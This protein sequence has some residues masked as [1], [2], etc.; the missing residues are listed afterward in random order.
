MKRIITIFA[1][2]LAIAG[3]GTQVNAQARQWTLRECIDYAVEHNIEIRQTALNVENAEIDLNTTQNSRLPNLNAG[4]GQNFSFGRTSVDVGGETPEYRNTQT[5]NTSAS[6]SAGMPLFQGFRISNQ[7]KADKLDLQAATENLERA[8]Q[9]LEL[10]VAALYLDVLFKK[11]I[12]AVY[13]EQTSLTRRQVDN[14]RRMVDEGKVARAQLLDIEAQLARNE[15]NEVTASNDLALS[16]L[17]LEQA[18]DLVPSPDFDV[19][20]VDADSLTPAVAAAMRSPETI[21]QTALGI[22]PSVREAQLRLRSAE[23]GVKI[24]RSAFFPSLSLSANAGVGYMY[25]FGQ[26]FPQASLAD[27]I[28]N[29]HSESVGLNLSI[30]IFNRNATRNGVRAARLGVMNQTLALDGVRLA[31][32]KEIQQAWQSAVAAEVRF[33]ATTKA[34]AASEEAFRA[35]ELRYNNGKATVYE[36][37]DANTTLIASRSEQTR[38][39]FDYLFSTKILEFYAGEQIDI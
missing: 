11:E 34:L 33:D 36:Y 30:P 38:A 2:L 18:L 13:R 23:Y 21:Y 6:I 17:N 15:V 31:L 9:N 37:S 1:G 20:E 35:M 39:R 24:A 8:K 7:L 26:D 3:T 4:L 16:L 14:T 19:A 5:S 32:Y 10:N 27:Q 25:M 29:R 22:K 28:R 12:L